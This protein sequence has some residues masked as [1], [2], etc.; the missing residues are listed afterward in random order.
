MKNTLAMVAMVAMVASS[1][2]AMATDVNGGIS[3]GGWTLQGRSDVLGIYG[4][5]VTTNP[6][7]VYTTVFIYDDNPVTG[8]P[9]GG[10]GV[11]G[12]FGSGFGNGDHILGVGIDMLGGESLDG[13]TYTLKIDIGNDSY[14]ASTTTIPPGDGHTSASTYAHA[15][16]F[17]VQNNA[18][19]FL[20]DQLVVY[21]GSGG[22][23]NISAE[24]GN[25]NGPTR[26]FA[27]FRQN[28]SYQIFV[29]L[30]D[31]SAWEI[32]NNPSA[33]NIPAFGSEL[34]LALNG[35]YNNNQVV[36]D[37]VSLEIAAV[38]EPATMLL[39]GIGIAGMAGSRLI[40]KKW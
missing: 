34:T 38:P 14:T 39:L 31:V 10:G 19:T 11:V 29:N 35:G 28:D 13:K 26:P 22:H 18:L 24:N 16:D 12:G 20:A 21:D 32:L 23:V 25:P 6:Y 33:P 4:S 37:D 3:W 36:I 8:S 27:S 40:R 5:G 17:N 15:G 30:T 2:A 1:G 7:N 9:V